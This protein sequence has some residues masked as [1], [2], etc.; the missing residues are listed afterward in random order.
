MAA[1]GAGGAPHSALTLRFRDRDLEHAFQ[2]EAGSRFRLQVLFTILLGAGTWAATGI[3]LPLIYPIDQSELFVSIG[4]VELLI[5][6]L[7]AFQSLARTWDQLQVISGAVNMIGGFAI[8]VIG[9]YVADQPH[10]VTPALL[11]NMLFAFGLSRLGVLVGVGITLPYVITF[12]VLVLAGR[13]PGVGLFEIFLLV[14]AVEVSTIADYLLEASTRNQFWLRRQNDAQS[15]ELAAEKDKSERLLENMLPSGLATRLMDQP[16]TVADR[17]ADVSVLFAD[18]VG[19]TPLA[20][21]LTPDETVALL[22]ELFSQFDVAAAQHGL[23]KIKTMGDA[24]MAVAGA[25][26][27]IDH[28]ARRAVLMGLSMIEIV[29]EF[30]QE[31][32][33]P[34]DLRVGINSGP[35]VAGVI[36]RS[37]LAYDL[38]GDTVNVAS[39]MESHGLPGAIQVSATTLKALGEEYQAE[40]RGTIDVRGKGPME[41][42]LIHPAWRGRRYPEPAHGT[43]QP[44]TP[45]GEEEA[46]EASRQ[47]D[48]AGEGTAARR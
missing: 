36:G 47:D 7:L 1:F 18:L 38:W 12:A 23:E 20:S 29:E 19:F 48:S 31:R 14:V 37:R 15:A 44:Q 17:Y 24:Y 16:G 40:P 4:V 13:L 8:I 3:L 45:S 9:A 30:A 28:P 26:D 32:G 5:L 41:T 27:P 21:R 33:L 11:V 34:L 22:N 6:S 43:A 2:L 46:V 39:R 35:A 42:F 25:P 10:L